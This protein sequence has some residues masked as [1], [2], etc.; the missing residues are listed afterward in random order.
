MAMSLSRVA[1][2]RGLDTEHRGRA[3]QN[4]DR[5]RVSG[6]SRNMTTCAP[7]GDNGRPPSNSRIGRGEPVYDVRLVSET[8]GSILASPS[9][10]IASAVRQTKL[11]SRD[12]QIV[13]GGACSA[14]GARHAPIAFRSFVWSSSRLPQ[15]LRVEWGEGRA[16]CC[17]G[18]QPT[19]PGFYQARSSH[20]SGPEH[21]SGVQRSLSQYMAFGA[22]RIDKKRSHIG[23]TTAV[24][25]KW[26]VA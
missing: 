24:A 8:G 19:E 18:L 14:P 23:T 12:Q 21:T 20:P 25:T 2:F 6:Y 10:D 26:L 15:P 17:C 3:L 11:N 16:G 13:R 9:E 22:A 5:G 1:A 4:D 7:R